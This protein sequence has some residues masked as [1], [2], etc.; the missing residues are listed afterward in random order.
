MSAYKKIYR[1]GVQRTTPETREVNPP[2]TGTLLPGTAVHLTAAAGGM[3]TAKG[4]ATLGGYIY[5]VGEPL[6]GTV[7]TDQVNADTSVRLYEIHSGDLFAARAVAGVALSDDLP[8]TID[9]DGRV[10][11]AIADDVVRCYVDM[12]AGEFPQIT[13]QTVLDQLIPVK[14]L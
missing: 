4:V 2:T 9:A 5:F 11:A 3:T 14:I 1:G 13:D 10:K 12:P 6:H 8:L 7:D